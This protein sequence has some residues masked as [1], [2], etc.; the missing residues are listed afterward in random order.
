MTRQS[1]RQLDNEMPE[2]H[3]AV[4]DAISTRRASS[5]A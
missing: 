3:A 2:V 1:F 5:T 4:A